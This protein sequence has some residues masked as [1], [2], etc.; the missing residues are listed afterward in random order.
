ML[1]ELFLCPLHGVELGPEPAP[2]PLCHGH[3]VQA[4]A[5][6]PASG[7]PVVMPAVPLPGAP[8]WTKA[9]SGDPCPSK[10]DISPS[11]LKG[12]AG[13][14]AAVAAQGAEGPGDQ[15]HPGVVRVPEVDV[16]VG[17]LQLALAINVQV[18]AGE[19][20]HVEPVWRE[21]KNRK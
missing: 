7:L 3:T 18:G 1:L 5:I 15:L 14:V 9:H 20:E 2:S 13:G 16:F 11:G 6:T 21:E 10:G 4:M 8:S 12:E 19:E 17:D